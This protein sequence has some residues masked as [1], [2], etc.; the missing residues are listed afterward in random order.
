MLKFYYHPLSPIARRVWI[1][2]LEKK[3]PFEPVVVDLRKGQH[4]EPNFLSLNPFHHVPA[5]VHGGVR[6]IES[7]AILDYLD[8]QFSKVPLSPVEPIAYAEMRMVQMVTTNELLPNLVSVAVAIEAQPLSEDKAK[9]IATCLQFLAQQLGEKEYF[10]GAELNLA[11]VV[12]GSTIPLFHR[13]GISLQ[14]YPALEQ[15]NL[16]VADRS[17]WQMTKP[18]DHDFQQWQRWIQIQ[19]KQHQRKLAKAAE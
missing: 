1:A 5:I 4:L 7:I 3:I 2:L 17:A 12:A 11:D 13:L 18:S 15:W 9:H 16:R 6:L 14:A 8:R 10:G 19:V